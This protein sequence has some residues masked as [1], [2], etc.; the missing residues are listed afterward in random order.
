MV[1][2]W[3]QRFLLKISKQRW[4]V[5]SPHESAR[6]KTSP[7]SC[8]GAWFRWMIMGRKTSSLCFSYDLRQYKS[9]LRET[10]FYCH[11]VNMLVEILDVIWT[12][13]PVC[14]LN[15]TC[16]TPWLL[17][18]ICLSTVIFLSFL[19]FRF[20]FYLCT[21]VFFLSFRSLFACL[22]CHS[23]EFWPLL[24]FLLPLWNS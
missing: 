15:P 7:D 20:L 10:A 8:D 21:F 24:S 23:L 13:T 3:M 18:D 6:W 1:L 4:N 12:F 11:A 19:Y 9:K 5:S 22:F 17:M 16:V 14:L 2:L